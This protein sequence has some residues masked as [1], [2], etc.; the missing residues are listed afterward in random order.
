MTVT[1]DPAA[2]LAAHRDRLRAV[3][4]LVPTAPPLP[5]PGVGGTVL[6][7]PGALG[8]E[9]YTR[10]DPTALDATWSE[11]EQRWLFARVARPAAM[12]ALL[13]RWRT[14]LVDHDALPAPE[15]AAF[16][17]WPSRDVAMTPVLLAHGLAPDQVLAVRPAGRSTV[18]TTAAGPATGVRVRRAGPADLDAVVA[19]YLHEVEF[20]RQLTGQ[21]PRPNTAA[22]MRERYGDALA[23]DEPT[24]WLAEQDGQPVG[25][26]SVRVGEQAAWISVQVAAA[27]MSYVDC[28]AVVPDRRGAGV[29]AALVAQAHRALDA[30]G[31]AATLL[32]YGAHNPLSGPFWHRGGYRPLRTRWRLSPVPGRS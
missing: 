25:M 12:S 9:R 10:L 18:D 4:P 22:L 6:S 8:V 3:D 21:A 14:H 13:T 11:L 30:A 31:I 24:V 23:V 16:V 28:A 1:D 19:L 32:H 7:V 17:P 2:V 26:I 15:C 20:G 5:E 27:P 29:G